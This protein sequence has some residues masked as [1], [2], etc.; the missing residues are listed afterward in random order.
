VGIGGLKKAK[1]KPQTQRARGFFKETSNENTQL[2]NDKSSTHK[3]K[4]GPRPTNHRQQV[5]LFSV[6]VFFADKIIIRVGIMPF[7]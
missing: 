6:K 5:P 1:K 7:F 2:N 3:R 4:K